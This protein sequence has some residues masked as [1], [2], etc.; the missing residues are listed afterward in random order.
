MWYSQ[1]L[2]AVWLVLEFGL[3]Y[4]LGLAIYR[5]Y[6]HPLRRIPGP[7]HFAVS[8]LPQAIDNQFRGV[9][10]RKVLHFHEKY[11]DI[12]RT[13]PNHVHMNGTIGWPEVFGH[14]R[15]GRPE[16]SHWDN[17][18]Q[19]RLL[20]H[21][22]SDAAIKEQEALIK[23]YVDK[24]FD[25]LRKEAAQEGPTDMLQWYNFTTFD[26]IGDLVF[27]EPF[28]CLDN[29]NYHPWISMIFASIRAG[30]GM[31]ALLRMPLL[32]WILR[33]IVSKED[34]QKRNEH[35]AM[36]IEKAERRIALGPAPNGRKDI[37]TY[38]LRHN[39][40]KGMT[41]QEILGN[42]EALI[43][44]GSETTAT[45]LSG[46]TYY[47][48]TNLQALNYVQREVR[49]AFRTE[50][51]ITMA[52]TTHLRYLH[53]CI[54]EAMRVYPPV[55]ETPPRISPGEYVNGNW[56]PKGTF[57]TIHQWA[58]YHNPSNFAHPDEG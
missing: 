7:K 40:E 9:F 48:S 8:G 27:G 34:I 49:A 6:L 18:Y 42:S 11:G 55:V 53:A 39:D 30:A 37:M 2:A 47:I 38:I 19:R 28:H 50:E 21:A 17:F 14:T 26:I 51:E 25:Q 44:A 32:H 20:A 33:L 4:A 5:I 31:M 36:S 23:Q 35:K 15:S 46:L 57:I 24:L 12:V 58:V 43:V 41:H 22:F 54:E 45:A 56:I 10:T 16:F 29:S 13:G 3:V 52:S 1:S